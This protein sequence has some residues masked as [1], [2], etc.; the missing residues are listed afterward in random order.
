MAQIQFPQTDSTYYPLKGGLDL[1]TKAIVLEPGK[2]IDAQNYEPDA[3]GGYR[4]INGHERFDGQPAPSEADYH[5]LSITLTGAIA[6]GATVTGA[7]SAATGKVL[8]LEDGDTSLILGRV[9]GTFALGEA[10]TVAAVTQATT[11]S[12]AVQNGAPLPAD[13]A[14]YKLLAA[15]DR[16]TD[17]LVVP[18]SGN[19]RGGFVYND[20]NY[21]FRDNAAGTAGDLYK[22]TA[23][24]WSQVAFGKEIQFT[25]AVGQVYAGDTVT[26]GTSA[27]TGVVVRALLRTGTWTVAG[28][29]TLILSGVTGTFQSGEALNVSAVTKVTSSSLCT[30]ITRAA[31][32][33]IVTVTA[34]FSGSTATKR[35]YGVD[36]VNKAFEFDGTN[37]IPIRTG[38][39]TDAPD[40]LAFH[41]ARLFLSFL[42][43]LQYSGINDPYSWTVL[44]GAAEIGMGD[45]ITGILPQSG[46]EAGAALAVFTDGKTSILYGSGSSDFNLVP[47]VNDLG[48]SAYTVQSVGNNAY[49]L[50]ARGIQSLRTTLNYG[51]FQ[52][53]A[54]SFFIQPLLARKLGL[55]TASV[56]LQTKNQYRI[57]FSDNSA[58]VVGLTG[59]KISGI[60]PLDY[61][62]PVLCV[63][64]GTLSTGEEVTFFG[65]DDG[66]VY[67]DNVGTS[68]DGEAIEA[69]VR[70]PFNNLKSPRVRKQYRRAVFEVTCE[71]YSVV[72][73]TYDLGYGTPDVGPIAVQQSQTLQGEG[74]YWDQFT[75]DAFTWD[76]PLVSNAEL[77]IDGAETNI[78]FLFY[79]NRAQDESHSVSGVTLLFTQ[80]RLV[81]AGS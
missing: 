36:G 23:S 46:N 9:S 6:V 22:E 28:A 13:N 77:S 26:G 7:T 37:Y 40:H 61:G 3:V 71:G 66:Y 62:K 44:T 32:G 65:S 63:W 30:D 1:V 29:G 53:A 33:R 27:A 18:G 12:L 50:T 74:G 52:Y 16:R 20:I 54:V 39:T 67:Q 60:M 17:I 69:W 24:G 43:S 47:S 38:M 10:L 79:S 25:G 11:T 64:G 5:F 45:D 55:Q 58:L 81:R 70:L 49:G 59:E 2:C 75:W 51:D 48:Y 15:N 19:I 8:G 57:F 73:A 56:S 42:G 72:N 14:D 76:S 80:R 31:G 41:K 78:G 68:F 21:V 35:I 4:R 34:N